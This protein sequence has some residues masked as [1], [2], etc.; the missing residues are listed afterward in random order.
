MLEQTERKLRAAEF[1]QAKFYGEAKRSEAECD[2]LK[3]TI[4]ALA[5]KRKATEEALKPLAADYQHDSRL[6]ELSQ[7]LVD[8]LRAL[9]GS[10]SAVNQAALAKKSLEKAKALE[11]PKAIV[12]RAQKNLTESEERAKTAEAALEEE[13]KQVEVAEAALASSASLS[14]WT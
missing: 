8:A 5:Q 3:A 12:D 1:E 10:L 11:Q 14:A 13:I 9:S 7:A 4:D 6:A 2:S